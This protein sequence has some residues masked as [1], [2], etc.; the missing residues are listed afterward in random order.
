MTYL[1]TFYIKRPDIG[2]KSVFLIK[3]KRETNE[4]SPALSRFNS[5]L[6]KTEC[7]ISVWSNARHRNL[8]GF[9]CW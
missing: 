2:I 9:R 1:E 8:T 4:S 5:I 7:I 3:K 6:I